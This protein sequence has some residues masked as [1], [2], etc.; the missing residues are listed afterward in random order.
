MAPRVVIVGASLAG[1]R[2]AEAVLAVLPE[3]KVTLVGAEDH[4]PY[5]RPPLSKEA[6]E[7]LAGATETARAAAFARLVFKHRLAEGAVDW[8]LG[9]RAVATDASA[10]M[11]RLSD[12]AEVGYDWLVAASGL[13]PR[14]LPFAGAEARRHVLRTFDDAVRL[15]AQMHAGR[16]MLV[17]GA[18][19]IGCEIAATAVKLGLS[20][21]V[22]EPLAQPML[23][24]LGPEVAAAMAGFHRRHGVD[25]CCG[26][27]VTGLNEKGLVLSDGNRAEGDLIVEAVGSIP[28]TE[29]LAGTGADLSNGILCDATLAATGCDRI[30]AAGDVARFPNA[31]LGPEPRRVEHWCVPGQTAKRAAETIAAREAGRQPPARFAPL[32]SFWSDQHGLRLQSFGAPGLGDEIRVLEGS[33]AGLGAAPCLVEYR[34]AG[35][36][37]GVL[38]LGAPP[39]A[40]AQHRVRLE[41]AL[42]ETM[43]A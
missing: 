2:S 22:V 26:L 8:R 4:A 43:A 41:A 19:F 15:A 14:R 12:G 1:L 23:A 9:V 30:L 20:V 7:A 27:A 31:L 39:A 13:R 33:L 18:G 5:N 29:W 11:L 40:L 21:T 6:A 16:G 24:A 37:V 3:A 42:N 10:R 28:N 35:Q 34:R 32:P 36:P 38:G 17:V 25:L